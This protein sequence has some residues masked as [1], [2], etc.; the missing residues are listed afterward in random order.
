MHLFSEKIFVTKN[1][2]DLI[3]YENH[4]RLTEKLYTIL[5]NLL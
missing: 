3:L 5:E 2:I 4:E 1:T